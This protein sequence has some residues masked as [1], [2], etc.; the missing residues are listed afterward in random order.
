MASEDDDLEEF[1]RLATEDVEFSIPKDSQ[2]NGKVE[3]SSET[4]INKNETEKS[5]KF[6]DDGMDSSDEE[7]LSNFF[8]QKYNQ[9]GSQINKMLKN[10]N[11]ERIDSIISKTVSKSLN[12][13][14]SESKSQPSVTTSNQLVPKIDDVNVYTDPVFGIRI[15]HPLL[16][17]KMLRERMAGRSAVDIRYLQNH[18]DNNDLS[19]DWC[20]CGVIVSKSPVQKSQK[21][22]QYII[23]KIS[24]LKGEIQTASI[25]LF[26]NAFKELW[27]TSVGMVVAILNPSTF[28]RKD[29]K[30]D[31]SLS[32]DNHIKV[33]MLGKSK[34]LGTCKSRKKNGDPCTNIVNLNSCE[35]CV[36]HVKQEYA[37]LSTRSELQSATSG[38]GLQSL[39]NKVLGKTEV[40]YAGKSFVA[41]KAVKSKKMSA[42]DNERLLSLSDNNNY[43]SPSLPAAMRSITSAIKYANNNNGRISKMA[44]VI[45]AS[46][47]QRSKDLERLKLLQG[48][49]QTNSS[50]SSVTTNSP[51]SSRLNLSANLLP[52]QLNKTPTLSKSTFSFELPDPSKVKAMELLK[53]KPIEKSNPN[54]VKYRGTENGKKRLLENLLANDS[55]SV[56]KKQKI[57]D[58]VELKRQERIN[59]VLNAKSAHTDLAEQHEINLQEEHF[60]KLEKREAME[61]KMINTKEVKCKAIICQQCKYKAFSAA[62]RCKDDKHPLKVIDAEKRFFECEDCG[63]RTVTLFRIPKTSCTNCQSSKWKRTGMM[64][65]RK[66]VQV[67]EE[68]SIRGD[69]EKFCGSL[70]TKAANINL[71]VAEE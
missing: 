56:K 64:K 46:T 14:K 57:E 12:E 49:T 33:M 65:E 60:N 35:Y 16:S 2:N 55:E 40:F 38:R 68:L 28:S 66:I 7:D 63:N 51:R 13:K 10:K 69:E 54:Y 19:Q 44:E 36:Y 43:N 59:A 9:Y 34:D 53:K 22:A 25:F 47:S 67:G 24:D 70:S 71:C 1:L 30:R 8:D 17:S 11:E 48:A 6:V 26:K 50:N 62:Q 39:R 3:S 18:L 45:E 52:L 15:I 27:K 61:E 42:K 29:D 21:G 23:W 37:R 32:V 41:E 20:I 4:Q 58:E 5:F 31:I